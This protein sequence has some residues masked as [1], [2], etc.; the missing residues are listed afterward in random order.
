MAQTQNRWIVVAGA[1][2]VQLALGAIYAWSVF[3][4]SLKEDFGFTAP[5][6]QAIFSVGLAVFAVA[7]IIAGRWLPKAGPRKVA[8]VGGVILGAAYIL[9]KWAG[10]GSEPFWGLFLTIGV[11]GG[12]GIGLA[13]VTPIAAG[14]KWF[15][16]K[17]GLVTGLAV[18]GFGFGAL[19]WVKLAGEWGLLIEKMGVLDVFALY[20]VIFLIMVVLGGLLLSF[21]PAGWTPAGWSPE[22]QAAA[23]ADNHDFEPREMVKTPQFY[24]LVLMFMF[25][26]M[27]GLMVIGN[28]KLFGISDL[29]ARGGYTKAASSAI[30][31]TAM[32]VFY[33]LANGV[34]R[35]VW[36]TISDYIGRRKAL[37]LM[38]GSQGIMMLLLYFTATSETLF[39]LGAMV[40]GF[41]FGGNFALFPTAVADFFGTKNVGKNYSYVF[42]AY[43][44]AGIAGPMIGGYFEGNYLTAFVIAGVACL[45][46]SG[47][48]YFTRRPHHLTD[49]QVKAYAASQ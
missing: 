32:A 46:A 8:I 33:S 19:L 34:G 44:F 36:G 21:P 13:Y 9:A 47:L 43:G 31:G 23:A 42:V 14:I 16:D 17:K 25:S 41:N 6:T 26:A 28:I 40:V 20:G 37:A 35:I 39:Y 29:A 27:A 1:L 18:A 11:L 45:A 5:Q 2:L 22:A 3:T 48:A 30:A 24:S 12:F 38:T 10:A 49:D 4:P 15:P 7:M